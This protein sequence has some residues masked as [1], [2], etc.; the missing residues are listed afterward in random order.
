MWLNPAKTGDFNA[1][2]RIG[3]IYR[4]QWFSVSGI[5]TPNIYVDAPIIRG[6]RDQDWVGVGFS[7]IADNAGDNRLNTTNSVLSAAYHLALDKDRDNVLTLGAQYANVSV[8]LNPRPGF[9]APENIPTGLGGGGISVGNGEFMGTAG[10]GANMDA[11]F[12]DNYTGV[13]AGL[14][15]R[16]KLADDNLLEVGFSMIHIGNPRLSLLSGGGGGG[17][18][19]PIGGN[20]TPENRQRP[21]TIHAHA[22]LDYGLTEDWR[23]QPTVFFQQTRGTS[24]ASIQ[25]WAGR[26]VNPDVMLKF[27]LGYRT[28]DAGQVLFGID[29]KDIR[30]ALSYDIPLGQTAPVD[31]NL[32]AF[33]L[34]AYYLIKIYKKPEV[35]PKILCPRL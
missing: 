18:G 4:G 32:G 13:N 19:N 15:L 17:G 35:T 16:S 22:S 2:A 14:M 33:E 5:N 10:G 7:L 30:A 21:A 23:L 12:N 3:G 31:R 34:S 25:A 28:A 20:N 1:T 11:P 8:T 24:S 26:Q 6:F 29:Y 9:L 27:G